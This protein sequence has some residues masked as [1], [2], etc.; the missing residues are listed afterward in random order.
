VQ[1]TTEHN[2]VTKNKVMD[3]S[4]QIN[5]KLSELAEVS[6]VLSN[7]SKLIKKMEDNTTSSET[8]KVIGALLIGT[9]IGTALGI[10]FAPAKG[11]ETR[12]MITGK[13]EDLKDKFAEFLDGMKKEYDAVKEK[14]SRFTDN[15]MATKKDKE[16]VS[17]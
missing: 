16:E 1:Q 17:R 4:V 5:L 6:T 12:K 15:G 2:Q 11:S 13:N 7:H 10:L 8:K 9:A 14:A 3:Y